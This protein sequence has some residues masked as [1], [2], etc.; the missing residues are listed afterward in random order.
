MKRAAIYARISET[1]KKVDKVDRQES[2]CRA[3]A[4][5]E[6]YQVKQ[7]FAD[8]GI[9]ASTFKQRPQWDALLQAILLGSFDV[10]LATED[11]RLTRQ[12]LEK[13]ALHRACIATGTV[14]H[15]VREGIT[16]PSDDDDEFMS[17]MRTLIGRKEVR[18]KA[19]RQRDAY[20][21]R[22]ASGNDLWGVRPFGFETDRMT[23]RADEA[24]VVRE[25]HRML[26]RGASFY[27]VA[28]YF[29]HSGLPTTRGK[30]WRTT[31][32]RKLMLRP[33]N[34]GLQLYRGEIVSDALP[35]IVSRDEH[36][37]VVAI[38]T[39][40]GR[41]SRPGPKVVANLASGLA[42]CSQC[43][44]PLR[45]S[46]VSSSV[47]GKKYTYAVY[48]CG[49]ALGARNDGK[50]HVSI[51]KAVLD[52]RIRSEVL[53]SFVRG[54][55]TAQRKSG[56]GERAGQ[57]RLDLAKLHERRERLND[58]YVLGSMDKAKLR[59]EL[60]PLMRDEES[61]SVELAELLATNAVEAMLDA[62]VLRVRIRDDDE[63]ERWVGRDVSELGRR[64]DAL[65]ID[66]RRELVRG[67]LRIVV[68]PGKGDERVT[69][70]HLLRPVEGHERWR[71]DS[72]SA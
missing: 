39:S 19:A 22:I 64:F 57:L 13:E 24:A 38:L 2:I 12:P 65:T 25:A 60:A 54:E 49:K 62:I 42:V 8:D 70:E 14:W 66:Q 9:S 50:R 71:L 5:R 10:V 32:V 44:Q 40:D 55:A 28:Q 56:S 34:A 43:G 1:D 46:N 29:E 52:A 68:M 15:T 47:N 36:E 27:S 58:L 37:A 53:E 67:L 16:D 51:R 21:A 72:T 26:L 11:E 30:G 59:R 17:G 20:E 48:R 7:V 69:V 4:E 41:D 23:L 31:S 61:M 63:H 45:A 3:L 33:R 6:G 18:R 35:A